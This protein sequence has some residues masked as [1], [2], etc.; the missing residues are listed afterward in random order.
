MVGQET[1]RDFAVQ[2]HM[3]PKEYYFV[4][5]NA[6]EQGWSVLYRAKMHRPKWVVVMIPRSGPPEISLPDSP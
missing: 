5:I 4:A 3:D 2:R 1:V 6:E